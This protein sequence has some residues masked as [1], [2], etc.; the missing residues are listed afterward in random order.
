M[1]FFVGY[2]KCRSLV[3]KTCD[4]KYEI[5]PRKNFGA[6]PKLHDCESYCNEDDDCKFFYKFNDANVKICL[7]YRSCDT[8]RTATVEGSTYSKEHSCPIDEKEHDESKNEIITQ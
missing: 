7:R 8:I 4:R 3:N 5:T 1:P 2:E 6:E